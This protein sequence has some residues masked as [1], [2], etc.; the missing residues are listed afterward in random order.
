MK[1]SEMTLFNE[2]FAQ[3]VTNGEIQVSF[4][5]VQ[6]AAT[7][8]VE[9]QCY[10]ALQKI[11]AILNNETLDDKECFQKIEEIVCILEEIGSNGGSRHDFG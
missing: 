9:G 8:V 6:G 11:K 1:E 10:Q 4:R 3:A 7:A 5:G 2:I